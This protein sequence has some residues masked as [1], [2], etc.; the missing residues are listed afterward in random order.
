MHLYTKYKIIKTI[1]SFIGLFIIFSLSFLLN[2]CSSKSDSE[3]LIE[4]KEVVVLDPI[5]YEVKGVD[6]E[7]LDNVNAQLNALPQISIQR[8]SLYKRE[9]RET[10]K[11]ALRALGYYKPKVYVY[12]KDEYLDFVAKEQKALGIDE[13]L[14]NTEDDDNK[15]ES[16]KDIK[17][18]ELLDRTVFV[19]IEKNKP[20][21]VRSFDVQVLGEGANYKTF[22]RA[23][24]NSNIRT[25]SILNH[26]NYENLKEQLQKDAYALGFFDAKFDAS[27][28]LVYQEQ[29]MADIEL[30]F[31][32]GVRYKIGDIVTNETTK[33]LLK[34]SQS[35]ITLKRGK[36]FSSKTINDNLSSLSE[37]NYYQSIDITPLLDK[38]TEDKEVPIKI[39][40]ARKK[41]NLMRVGIGYSTDEQ[42][43][44]LFE[45]D[46]PL[47]NEYGHS[48]SM[49]TKLSMVTQEARL[50]Y[51]IPYRNP[52]LDY[53][54][55]N[56]TQTHTDINDTLSDRSHLSFHY[57]AD[58]E[59]R[60]HKDFAMNVEYEDF[61]QASEKGFGWNLFPSIT[62]AR[63]ES[64]G[65]VDPRYGYYIGVEGSAATRAISDYSF[66][67]VVLTGKTVLSPT[68]N[69]R[70]FLKVQQ[71]AI[72]GDDSKHLP[73][74]MRFFVGGDNSL[75]GYGY[76]QESDRDSKGGL[77]GGRYMTAG[78]A[79]LQFPI[80]IAN[81]RGALFLDA[82][83]ACNEYTDRELLFGPGIGYRF[84]SPY[85]TL[86]VDLG[87]AID[88]EPKSVKLHFAF[89][90][91]F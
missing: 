81:S 30:I 7:V 47:L 57:V 31:D 39:D 56:A 54:Y 68:E 66:Y 27:R 91:E 4:N 64:T 50:M 43:R 11:L 21:F 44:V 26:G 2:A 1:R 88:K 83:T 37:T 51:K 86:R 60:W 15:K 59:K 19:Y 74:S 80:G 36:N 79:E 82:A 8:V 71:G 73:P 22:K 90:P 75:R 12:T 14:A 52:N 20:L 17:K 40:L 55:I 9:I 53:F 41:N 28:I 24:N 62:I 13:N 69:T 77:I 78:T 35:L 49:G 6:G 87:V 65:G 85:G 3:N 70:L 34:P 61:T 42:A 63:R 45:W 46:K 23:I 10:A 29:N 16:K 25:Y 76:L 67:R 18:K 5:S 72:F 32:T 58:K 84:N 33:E 48:M 89:G 38:K